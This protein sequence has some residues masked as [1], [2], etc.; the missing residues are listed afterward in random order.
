MTEL[1][2]QVAQWKLHEKKQ[3]LLREDAELIN[4]PDAKEFN[5]LDHDD[6]SFSCVWDGVITSTYTVT[7]VGQQP[8]ETV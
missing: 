1:Q 2:R 3:E 4:A 6:F 8:D 5:F 7:C